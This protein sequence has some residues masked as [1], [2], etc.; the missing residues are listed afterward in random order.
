MAYVNRGSLTYQIQCE[1]L[2]KMA[3]GESKHAA[4][5]NGTHTSK[6]Y[7]YSTLRGY[8]KHANYFAKWAK[9]KYNCKTLEDCKQYVEQYLQSRIDSGLAASTI[10]LDASSLAKLYDCSTKDFNITT[11]PR[12]R[13]DI[14][15]SRG[16]AVRDKH[17][18]IS[19]NK[20]LVDFCRSTGL[21]RDELEQLRGDK[22]FYK[23][24]KP[25]LRIDI[26]S[27][28]GKVRDVPVIGTKEEIKNVINKMREAGSEKVF[29][30]A[31][32]AAD[33]HGFR[34]DYAQ[35]YYNQ[36]ARN[37]EEIPYDRIN[38]GTGRAYQS[39][40]YN[41]RGDKKGIKYDKAA[42][43]IVSQALGHNRISVI[44]GNYLD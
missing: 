30:K 40:V 27:K 42:M 31:H 9:E 13:A 20:D 33:I 23:D 18:S 2:G 5:K 21:R 1:L 41:C 37:T 35:N 22:L 14:T 26:G 38:K 7:S 24:D 10:K 16:E 28:G 19:N 6:I 36:L 12:L 3:P 15:R 11:P 25:Y 39:E 34:R 29:G 32:N 44:A 4:K 17:F 8:M 43:R